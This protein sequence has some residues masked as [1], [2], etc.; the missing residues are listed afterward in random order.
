M[1]VD[2]DH[3]LTFVT[4]AVLEFTSTWVASNSRVGRRIGCVRNVVVHDQEFKVRE[5]G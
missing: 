4:S 1:G 3:E 2:S 5:S